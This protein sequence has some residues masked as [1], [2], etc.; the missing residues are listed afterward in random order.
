MGKYGDAQRD[1]RQD[2]KPDYADFKGKVCS[3]VSFA[4]RQESTFHLRRPSSQSRVWEFFRQL[5]RPVM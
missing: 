2:A 1:G 4:K 3:H 5:S